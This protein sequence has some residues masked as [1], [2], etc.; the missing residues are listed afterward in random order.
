MCKIVSIARLSRGK[1]D[2]T[3]STRDIH[4]KVNIGCAYVLNRQQPCGPPGVIT[5]RL[6][7]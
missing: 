7:D 5:D 1:R 3:K 6:I 2:I 4:S